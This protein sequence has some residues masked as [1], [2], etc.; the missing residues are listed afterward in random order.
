MVNL[1][2]NR[3]QQIKSDPRYIAINVVPNEIVDGVEVSLTYYRKYNSIY[4]TQNVELWIVKNAKVNDFLDDTKEAYRLTNV[5]T[6]NISKVFSIFRY[7]RKH[8]RRW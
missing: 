5:V 8:G 3:I 2:K 4:A 6:Q 7:G 1:L